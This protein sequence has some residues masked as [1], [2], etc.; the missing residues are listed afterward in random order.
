MLETDGVYLE[1]VRCLISPR[2]RMA[3]RD[4][5]PSY[6]TVTDIDEVGDSCYKRRPADSLRLGLP[7]F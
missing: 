1:T 3:T 4:D 5:H 2:P 6:H 7:S